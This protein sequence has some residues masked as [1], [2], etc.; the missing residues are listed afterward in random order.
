[1]TYLRGLA[2]KISNTVVDYASPGSKEWAEAL[3]REV[4]FVEGDWAALGWALGSV[5]I[6]FRY[7]KAPIRSFADLS[8]VAQKFAEAKRIN[9][10]SLG[11]MLLGFVCT[12]TLG[13]SDARSWPEHT[14]GILIALGLFSLGILQ[15]IHQRNRLKVPPSDDIIALI[16]F[17]KAELER[18][19]RFSGWW[20]IGSVTF[21]CLGVPLTRHGGFRAHPY[22]YAAFGLL[23]AGAVL[24]FLLMR[25]ANRRRLE[26]IDMLLAEKA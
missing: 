6:L 5:R 13:F 15:L 18:Y 22:W 2:L 14:G 3:A 25:R 21:F 19:Y 24:W 4:A 17:Y 12:Y 1:M 9:Q 20:A 16:Q 11:I 8:S 7:K 10:N 26:Q 23:W